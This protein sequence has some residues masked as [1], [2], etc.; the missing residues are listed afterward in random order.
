MCPTASADEMLYY[1]CRYWDETKDAGKFSSSPIFD[2]VLG[3][4]GSGSGSGN[5]L[6]NG[7]FVNLTVN[8]GPGFTTVPRCVNRRITDFLSAQC[9]QSY[10]DAA[11]DHPDY[12]TALDGIYSGPHLYGHMAL[13][14]MVRDFVRDFL[15]IKSKS[16]N[17]N[18]N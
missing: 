15:S 11:L 17:S 6:T 14:M 8:I 3:F 1:Y 4:G 9:G 12:L 10:V 2:P 16:S 7:P 13:A 5:C 18:N